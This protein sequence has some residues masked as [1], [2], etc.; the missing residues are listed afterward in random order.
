MNSTSAVGN[1]AVEANGYDSSQ[2]TCFFFVQ[3]DSW[4]SKVQ[5]SK[6]SKYLRKARGKVGRRA[7]FFVTIFLTFGSRL[8]FQNNTHVIRK[9]KGCIT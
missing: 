9:S 2:E 3:E 4:S 7:L 1:N 5:I 8:R 6:R